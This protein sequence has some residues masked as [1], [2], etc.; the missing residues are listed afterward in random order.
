M[1]KQLINFMYALINCVPQYYNSLKFIINFTAC[2]TSSVT[3]WLEYLSIFGHL[4]HWKL[5]QKCH[6]FAT[7]GSAF[8]Q[9]NN[10]NLPNW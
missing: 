5:A 4:L 1:P 6:K 7:V 2:L 3:R 8:C 9:I 10:R